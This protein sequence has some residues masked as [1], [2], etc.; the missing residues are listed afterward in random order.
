MTNLLAFHLL[1]LYFIFCIL[2]VLRFPFVFVIHW[3]M[4][5]L[6]EALDHDQSIG[7]SPPEGSVYQSWQTT[8][9]NDH[10]HHFLHTRDNHIVADEADPHICDNVIESIL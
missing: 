9:G 3:P 8:A 10:L 2:I 6:S 4:P 7:L 5:G 1:Y